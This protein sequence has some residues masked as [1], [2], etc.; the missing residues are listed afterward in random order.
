MDTLST[1]YELVHDAFHAQARTLGATVA[2]APGTRNALNFEFAL[3][4]RTQV[5]AVNTLSMPWG[6]VTLET[7]AAIPE[8]QL[9]F[10]EGG[11]DE[12]GGDG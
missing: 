1:L 3:R 9:I 2:M 8:G 10:T 6:D 7:D 5:I 4:N 11:P 12:G